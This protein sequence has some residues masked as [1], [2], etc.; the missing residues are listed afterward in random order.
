MLVVMTNF[1]IDAD[2]D[3]FDN[4][5]VLLGA[6]LIEAVDKL[7]AKNTAFIKTQAYTLL[8]NDYRHVD[9]QQELSSKIVE[10][11][12]GIKL[13]CQGDIN[14]VIFKRFNEAG[15]QAVKLIKA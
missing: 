8:Q 2:A 11:I 15:K 6:T 14:S 9:K 7:D 12:A 4:E 5:P 3:G 10:I 13:E 1:Y